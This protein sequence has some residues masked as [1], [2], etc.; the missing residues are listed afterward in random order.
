M[1][2]YRSYKK[3]NLEAFQKD[4]V[5]IP[6]SYLSMFDDPSDTYWAYEKMFLEVLNEHAPMKCRTV[7]KPQLP[8]MNSEIR[9]EMFKRNSLKKQI[10]QMPHGC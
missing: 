8:Y 7:K 6:E 9:K 5:N 1:I 2:M 4:I 10:L 3:F